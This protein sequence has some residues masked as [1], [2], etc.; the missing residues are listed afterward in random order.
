[1][2]PVG[3]LLGGVDFTNLFVR[4]AGPPAATLA[5]AKEAG[6]WWFAR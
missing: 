2:P 3:L 1:M 4:L 5:E 6:A